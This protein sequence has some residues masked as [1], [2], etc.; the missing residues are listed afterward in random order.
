M[1]KDFFYSYF[2]CDLGCQLWDLCPELEQ[3][4]ITAIAATIINDSIT[5]LIVLNFKYPK[6]INTDNIKQGYRC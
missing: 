2:L 4:V 5:F 1:I 6:M 3:D